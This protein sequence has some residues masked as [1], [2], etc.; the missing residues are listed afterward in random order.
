MYAWLGIK[1]VELGIENIHTILE[2]YIVRQ[3]GVILSLAL[4]GYWSL[5]VFLVTIDTKLTEV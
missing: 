1:L 3:S 4:P 5:H 2:H